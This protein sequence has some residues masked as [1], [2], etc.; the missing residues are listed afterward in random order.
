KQL[1]ADVR[2]G[3]IDTV[4]VYKVDR[5][6]RSRCRTAAPPANRPQTGGAPDAPRAVCLYAHS[7]FLVILGFDRND[8]KIRHPEVLDQRGPESGVFNQDL[9]GLMQLRLL[10]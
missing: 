1:L 9:G 4:L 2:S 7:D 5:L 3:K 10:S 6:T 8:R